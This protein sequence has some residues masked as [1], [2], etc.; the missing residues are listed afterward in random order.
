MREG[1]VLI[2]VDEDGADVF[3][4]RLAGVG[5]VVRKDEEGWVLQALPEVCDGVGV[6][7]VWNGGH[8][9]LGEEVVAAADVEGDWVLRLGDL[10]EDVAVFL[11]GS[12]AEDEGGAELRLDEGGEFVGLEESREVERAGI[13]GEREVGLE[14]V[15]QRER[16][17]VGLD[18][19][20]TVDG[21][22]KGFD[23]GLLREE[24]ALGEGELVDGI[25]DSEIGE[26]ERAREAVGVGLAGR[27]YGERE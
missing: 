5:D 4:E 14:C 22:E 6:V 17:S 2:V 8:G 16:F 23:C 3:G 18:A 20:R 26:Q 7:G 27:V 10:L 11:V 19:A 24:E 13:A 25:V 12:V 15:V 1:G 9:F 21:G